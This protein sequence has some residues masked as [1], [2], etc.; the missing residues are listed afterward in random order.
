MRIKLFSLIF[1]LIHFAIHT[2]PLSRSTFQNLTF[3]YDEKSNF[4]FVHSIWPLHTWLQFSK[5]TPDIARLQIHCSYNNSDIERECEA[6]KKILYSPSFL[7]SFSFFFLFLLMVLVSI[8]ECNFDATVCLF[9]WLEYCEFL[10][11]LILEIGKI[12]FPWDM[13]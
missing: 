11:S 7:L 4:H 9:G 1:N 3:K 10:E 6:V 5:I 8:S 12:F 13:I 2:F